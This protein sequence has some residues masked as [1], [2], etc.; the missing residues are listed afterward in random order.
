MDF[1]T[2]IEDSTVVISIEVLGM[3][4]DRM[5]YYEVPKERKFE[6]E[7]RIEEM[8][9]FMWSGLY[10]INGEERDKIIAEHLGIRHIET[11]WDD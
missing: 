5:V 1:K 10:G 3:A 9:C 6:M 2:K 8:E 11:V 4:E 7:I